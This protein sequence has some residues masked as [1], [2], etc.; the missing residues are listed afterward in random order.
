MS[1]APDHDNRDDAAELSAESDAPEAASQRRER[2]AE[3]KASAVRAREE[4][5]LPDEQADSDPELNAFLD[6]LVEKKGRRKSQL[7]LVKGFF[8]DPLRFGA[9]LKTIAGGDDALDPAQRR[10]FLEDQI[11][12]LSGILEAAEAEL[13]LLDNALKNFDSQKDNQNQS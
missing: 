10:V 7:A 9:G 6:D 4:A 5:G 8:A 2:L 3:L 11:S 1:S 13:E 12:L